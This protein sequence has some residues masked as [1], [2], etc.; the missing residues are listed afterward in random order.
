M[1]IISTFNEQMYHSTGKGMLA[2]VG[3]FIPDARQVVYEE[4]DTVE[5][6]IDTVKVTELKKFTTVFNENRDVITKQFGGDAV[7][8][9]GDKSWNIRWFGWFRKVLMNHHAICEVGYDDYVIFVDSDMRF[10]KTF[11]EQFIKTATQGKAVSYFRGKRAAIDSGFVVVNGRDPN[12]VKFYDK[13]MNTFLTKEFRKLKRWDD[14]YVLTKNVQNCP[15]EWTHD[16]AAGK[17][18]IIHKNTTGYITGGQVMPQSA[19]R[20]YIEHDKG[21]HWKRD[22]VPHAGMHDPGKA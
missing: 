6:D 12:A 7:D 9:A 14:G 16:F 20:D 3:K 19:W 1:V 2:S 11:D 21:I 8:V 10:V 18:P 17:H 4:F 22:I 13:F 5:L 15:S